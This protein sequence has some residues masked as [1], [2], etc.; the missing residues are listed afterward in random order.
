MEA[1]ARLRLP[2]F[3]AAVAVAAVL[4]CGCGECHDQASRDVVDRGSLVFSRALEG[5]VV[6]GPLVAADGTVVAASNAGVLHG[7]D[8]HTGGDRWTFDG[9]GSYGID[10][11]TSPVQLRDGTIL[12]PGPRERVYALTP[13]GR[14]KWSVTLAGMPLT[15]AVSADERTLYVQSMSGELAAFDR[16][17]GLAPYR[18]WSLTVGGT[19]YGSPALS[20][21]VVYATADDALIAVTD[22]G[23]SARVRW[24]FRARGLVEVSPAVSADGTVVLGTND[25]YQYGVRPDGRERWRWRR[26]VW[27]YSSPTATPD[28]LV[29]FGDHRGRLIALD[30]ATGHLVSTLQGH[31][32]VWGRP[33]VTASGTVAFG[34]H[35]GE[36]FAFDRSGHKVIHATTQASVDSS[37]AI[38]PD[39]TVYIGSEDGRLYALRP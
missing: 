18:R 37:P 5:P 27:T 9:G 35:G 13:N 3:A 26:D 10:L 28:G 20:G 4:V 14:L 23:S 22:R 21:H 2:V 1:A 29:R 6:P 30:G 34:T 11:S 7:L 36:V 12:W 38:G 24:R 32:Q 15:P 17:P 39:G 33:A 19:S 25:R 8:P 16:R 31:G